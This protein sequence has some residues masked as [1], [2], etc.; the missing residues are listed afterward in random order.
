MVNS[1]EFIIS[2]SLGGS[3][4][5]HFLHSWVVLCVLFFLFDS[6][7]S[8]FREQEQTHYPVVNLCEASVLSVPAFTVRL[9]KL[10]DA[11]LPPSSSSMAS[12]FKVDSSP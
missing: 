4:S 9:V 1:P 7:S 10:N 6:S 2:S 5:S 3:Q 8:L 12:L 11:I